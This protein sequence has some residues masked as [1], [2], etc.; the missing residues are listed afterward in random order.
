MLV[1]G[2]TP[3]REAM[4][5]LILCGLAVLALATPTAAE[6]SGKVKVRAWEGQI[7]IPTYIWEEAVAHGT[8][9]A[10]AAQCK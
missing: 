2:R 1:A 10:H 5:N 7:T 6:A 9:V 4:K 3:E 8:A